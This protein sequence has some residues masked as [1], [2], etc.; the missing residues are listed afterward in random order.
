MDDTNSTRF[1]PAWTDDESADTVAA[2]AAGDS[3][4]SRGAS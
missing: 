2:A 1:P 4:P 3:S